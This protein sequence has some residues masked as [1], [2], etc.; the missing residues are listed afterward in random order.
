MCTVTPRPGY[1]PRTD[2][3]K[4]L[5][6]FGGRVWINEHDYE[7]ARADVE[8]LEDL[9]FGLGLLARVHHGSRFQILRR[10]INNEVWLPAEIR[11]QVSARIALLKRIRAEGVSTFTDYKKFSVQTST[12]FT[13]KQ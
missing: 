13:P 3:G 12:T 8:V 1:T 5:K 6:K 4:L 10:K 9:T 2:N 11:Y 7:L